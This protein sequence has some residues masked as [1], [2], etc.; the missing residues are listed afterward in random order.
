MGDYYG[1][2]FDPR[3]GLL[4]GTFLYTDVCTI[5]GFIFH[6]RKRKR[7]E[8]VVENAIFDG[9]GD[10]DESTSMTGTSI[11]SDN[12]IK[13]YEIW[14]SLHTKAEGVQDDCFFRTM[15]GFTTSNLGSME[16]S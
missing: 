11:Q 14:G 7:I 4:I 12:S 15:Q 2:S 8:D 16:M 9:G 1:S 3:R 10:D 6:C 5:S 13:A